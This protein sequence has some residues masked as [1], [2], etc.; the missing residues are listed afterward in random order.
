VGGADR[1]ENGSSDQH[2]E[3]QLTASGR[4]PKDGGG[5]GSNVVEE[6]SPREVAERLKRDPDSLVLLDVREPY[7][8]EAASIEPSL[9]IPMQQVPS[10]TA[11]IPRD[12]PVVVYCHMGVRSL[13][14]ASYLENHGFKGLANLRGGIHAW[15]LDVDPSVPVYDG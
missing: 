14:V 10:R 8:R 5:S 12:R 7:E 15:S 11:E 9:F 2:P 13:M 1:T 6:I 4:I 3:R